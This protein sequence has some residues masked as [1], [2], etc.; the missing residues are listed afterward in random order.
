M[1]QY[2]PKKKKTDNTTV[3]YRGKVKAAVEIWTKNK[4][5]ASNAN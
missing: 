1:H 4:L 3:F 2:L 5:T